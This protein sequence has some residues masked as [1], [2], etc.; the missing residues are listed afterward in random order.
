M[1][2]KA[3][4]EIKFYNTLKNFQKYFDKQTSFIL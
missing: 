1:N 4:E 2:N 3:I